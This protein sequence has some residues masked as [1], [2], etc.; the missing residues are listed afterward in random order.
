MGPSTL[1]IL[2]SL[3]AL[4]RFERRSPF[5]S[6]T[7]NQHL[8]LSKEF[9]CKKHASATGLSCIVYVLATANSM[10]HYQLLDSLGLQ[11]DPPLAYGNES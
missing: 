1:S 6:G 2:L 3:A 9:V 11:A 8:H 4:C 10:T 5:E 7:G